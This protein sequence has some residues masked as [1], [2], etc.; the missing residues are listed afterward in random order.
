MNESRAEET[1]SLVCR[2]FIFGLPLDFR[3]CEVIDD[4][5]SKPVGGARHMLIRYPASRSVA[6]NDGF[7]TEE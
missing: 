2:G 7:P 5:S 4:M 3:P 6:L 1:L